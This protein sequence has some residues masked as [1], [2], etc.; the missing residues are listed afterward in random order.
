[1][2]YFKITCSNGYCGCSEEW[3]EV[4]EDTATAK[5]FDYEDY[6][7]N[8]SFYDPD[9]SFID[10]DDFE[11]EEE[12]EEACREYQDEISFNVTEITREEY[13]NERI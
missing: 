11:T 10:P 6:F 1:M 12:Y 8:Y 4:A 9:S 5:D 7:Q 13:E 3:Y 2:K